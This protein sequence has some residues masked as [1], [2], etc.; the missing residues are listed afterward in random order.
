MGLRGFVMILLCSYVQRPTICQPA[1]MI[2]GCLAFQGHA[3]WLRCINLKRAQQT[4]SKRSP[5]T[6]SEPPA[7]TAGQ[8]RAPTLSANQ[9]ERIDF[10]LLRCAS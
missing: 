6:L 9:K 1:A 2:G 10:I 4:R 8:D 7:P 3:C 5:T